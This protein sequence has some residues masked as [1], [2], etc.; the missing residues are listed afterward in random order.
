MAE[1][2]SETEIQDDPEST[3]LARL[4]RLEA[5]SLE[6]IQRSERRIIAAEMKVE[7]V[8]SGMIDLDGLKFLEMAE[9]QLGE[10]G[11]VVGGAELIGQLK[12]TKPWLFSAPSSSSTA[13]VPSAKH[14]RHKVA[15]EMTDEEYRIARANI[16]KH[17]GT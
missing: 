9:I 6:S 8:R 16:V 1:K 4:D 7:A 11:E 13:R 15:T 10:D 14:V 3:F 2:N 5:M 17:S 12:K